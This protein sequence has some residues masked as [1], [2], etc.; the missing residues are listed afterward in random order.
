MFYLIILLPM[1]VEQFTLPSYLPR[2]GC[3]ALFFSQVVLVVR[4]IMVA[5]VSVYNPELLRDGVPLGDPRAEYAFPLHD[6]VPRHDGVVGTGSPLHDGVVGTGALHDGV[7]GTGT[8]RIFQG[9]AMSFLHV[10]AWAA[11]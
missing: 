8:G 9:C 10:S 11:G 5:A 4:K 2:N 3:R 6:G 1:D 7:V